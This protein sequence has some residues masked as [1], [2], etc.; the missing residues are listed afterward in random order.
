VGLCCP[1]TLW[2]RLTVRSIIASALPRMKAPITMLTEVGPWRDRVPIGEMFLP[3]TPHTPRA[4]CSNSRRNE[5]RTFERKRGCMNRV[6]WSWYVR[7][8][9]TTPRD[10]PR[11]GQANLYHQSSPWCV[12]EIRII[13]RWKPEYKSALSIHRSSSLGSTCL[14]GEC[15]GSTI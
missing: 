11:A 9:C 7:R 3:Q 10:R 14:E 6:I 4:Q 15:F 12:I 13:R 5:M 8:Q 2:A 1:G